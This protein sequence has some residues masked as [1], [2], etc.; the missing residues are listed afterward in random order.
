[1][2]KSFLTAAP[3][4]FAL[5]LAAQAEDTAPLDFCPTQEATIAVVG[6]SL[7]DGIWGAIY[8]DFLGCETVSVLRVTAVSDGLTKSS[9]D[10]WKRRLDKA[11]GDAPVADLVLV[12]LGANDIKPVRDGNGRALFGDPAWDTAYVGRASALATQLAQDAQGLIWLGLPIVGD[13]DREADY[14][15]VSTLQQQTVA[16]VVKAAMNVSFLDIHDSS[17]FGTGGFTQNAEVD[18]A[19]VQ[20]RA[21][22]KVHFTERGYDMI[23][24]LV[25]PEVI[26]LLKAKDAD[27]ALGSVAL[28]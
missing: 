7:A 24:G 13:A 4:L 8:R 2:L 20:L 28:Q 6:D 9:P 15:H 5:A 18:G 11:I 10:E 23:F 14:R 19:T 26:A 17:M 3:V 22:D 21:N 16:D 25:R 12:Q 1:M 27:A